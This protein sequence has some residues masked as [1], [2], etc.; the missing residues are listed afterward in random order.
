ME[1]SSGY[2]AHLKKVLRSYQT[3]AMTSLSGPGCVLESEKRTKSSEVKS[4]TES[5]TGDLRSFPPGD[6]RFPAPL[7][8]LTTPDPHGE[9]GETV[10]EGETISCF[11]VGGEDRLCL[12]QILNTVLR[13]F[14]LV[15][16]N[17]VC[18]ELQIYC[19]RCNGAQLAVLKASRIIPISAPTCGLITKT[20]A[21][22]LCRRLLHAHP[23]LI[24]PEYKHRP[25]GFRVYHGC[26]GKCKGVC[27]PDW[28]S[29][30]SARC[31][32]CGDCGGLLSP[33]NFVG[34]VHKHAENRTVHWGFDSRR[35]RSYLLLARGQADEESLGS[36]LEE[37]KA[38]FDGSK[39]HKRKQ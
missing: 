20:D 4:E 11:T 2:P 29:S 38:R 21:E 30:P 15:Q 10:L 28:Y 13:E 31:I 8:I 25:F 5:P 22:R 36:V 17:S 16:I 12:P 35:W 18:D 26:F 34:H 23:P 19:S 39:Q 24:P 14:T 3:A 27:Y 9:R 33:E 1:T 32:E 37:I 7:P 6:L